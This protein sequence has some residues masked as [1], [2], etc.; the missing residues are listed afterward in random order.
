MERTFRATV[1]TS[2][3]RYSS[4]GRP[5]GEIIHSFSCYIVHGKTHCAGSIKDAYSTVQLL[6]MLCMFQQLMIKIL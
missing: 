6:C 2:G 4:C 1:A 3:Q 5:C